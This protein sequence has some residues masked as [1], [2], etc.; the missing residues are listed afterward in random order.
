M[1]N[2]KDKHYAKGFVLITL[3]ILASIYTS[4]IKPID[5]YNSSRIYN[6]LKVPAAYRVSLMNKFLDKQYAENS[7]LI[8]GDSQPNGFKYPDKDIFSTLLSKKLNKKVINAAFRDAR[9]LDSQNILTYLKRKNMLFDT[10]IYNVNPAHAKAPAQYRLDLN[11]SVDYRVGIF[12]NSNIFQD[13]PNHFNPTK[14][15]NNSF[16]NYPSLPNFFDMPEEE[17]KLYLEELKKLITLAKSVSKQVIIYTTSHYVGDFKR[18][19]LNS[20]TLNKLEDKVLTICKENNVTFLKPAITEKKYFKDIVHFNAKGHIKMSEI[21]Y[22][23][24]EK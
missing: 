22:K 10:I 16:Y 23:V 12:K 6:L 13:F 17:V 4:I 1:I 18:L 3:L 24:I 8:L 11:N 15:P 21:L 20:S 9:V 5:D 14:T 2:I 19:D 7:I